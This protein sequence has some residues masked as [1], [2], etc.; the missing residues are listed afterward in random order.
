MAAGTSV[1]LHNGETV[2]GKVLV[3]ADGTRSK[4][5][6]ALNLAPPSYAG[7]SAYRSLL[8]HDPSLLQPPTE[9]ITH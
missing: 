5:A 6:A 1:T 7:Y 4:V 2:R 8:F 9:N 3:G